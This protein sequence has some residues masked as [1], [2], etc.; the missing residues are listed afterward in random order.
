MSE[1]KEAIK[2]LN[3]IMNESIDDIS[4]NRGSV[5]TKKLQDLYYTD[6][7]AIGQCLESM[8]IYIRALTEGIWVPINED[9]DLSYISYK[10]LRLEKSR[11]QSSDYIIMCDGKKM[12][13]TYKDYLTNFWLREG[14]SE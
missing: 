6:L 13:W 3:F 10:Y 11:A 7:C 14:K 4:I 12:A 8:N 9:G 2:S 5:F 1:I